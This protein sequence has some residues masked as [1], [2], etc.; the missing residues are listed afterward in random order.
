MLL[1][2]PDHHNHDNIAEMDIR[3]FIARLPEPNRGICYALIIDGRD[4]KSI[5]SSFNINPRTV[6]R[7]SRIAMAPLALDYDISIAIIRPQSDG[8]VTARKTGTI[9][10]RRP[11][12]GD[13][14]EGGGAKGTT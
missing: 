9:K 10:P 3:A 5:A 13:R 1:N 2:E 6:L 12:Q 8:K 14:S 7:R 11:H 4:T